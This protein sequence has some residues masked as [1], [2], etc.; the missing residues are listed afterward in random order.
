MIGSDVYL[1]TSTI[2]IDLIKQ[3][4]IKNQIDFNS[5]DLF[6]FHQASKLVLDSLQ[7]KLN[8][9]DDKFLRDIENV[10]NT[11]S[12]T[13]PIAL[14]NYFLKNSSSKPKKIFVCGFGVG[15]SIGITILEL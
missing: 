12:N 7:K 2:V 4:F 13:I 3:Y 5:I 8:I 15:L 9:S 11:V 14:S 1:F 6:V 10:G